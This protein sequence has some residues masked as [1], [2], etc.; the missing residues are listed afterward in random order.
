MDDALTRTRRSL[1]A[2]AE[3]LLA[4]PQWR[5]SR[6]IR[7]RVVPGGFATVTEPDLQVVGTQISAGEAAYPIAGTAAELGAMLGIEACGLDDVYHGGS[8]ATLSEQ[9]IVDADAARRLA[10]ALALGDDALAR[11]APAAERVLWPEH[12]D[13]AI[14]VDDINY[15]V[16]PGDTYVAEPYAYVGVDPVPA[17]EFWNMPFGAARPVSQFAGPDEAVAFFAEGRL[18]S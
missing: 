12:F 9:L 14:R 17:G 1:H 13:I 3:L 18:L 11:F 4:G 6:D 10:D 7:L 2:A 8:G 16:S 15:G 5:R